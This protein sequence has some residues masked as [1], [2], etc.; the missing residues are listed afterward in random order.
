MLLIV[1][2][3]LLF[4]TAVVK[5]DGLVLK[6]ALAILVA[7]DTVVVVTVVDAV[8]FTLSGAGVVTLPIIITA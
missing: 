3:T 5:V 8:L 7:V 2:T 4:T 1:V 6:T